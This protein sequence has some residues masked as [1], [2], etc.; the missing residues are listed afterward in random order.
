[1]KSAAQRET[2]NTHTI[3]INRNSNG[4]NH[5]GI[6]CLESARYLQAGIATF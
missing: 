3:H 5:I 6:L 4:A 1:M 2:V